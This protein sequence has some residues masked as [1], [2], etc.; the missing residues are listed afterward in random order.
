MNG[1]LVPTVLIAEDDP[2]DLFLI[3]SAVQK[4]CGEIRFEFV[5]DGAEVISYLMGEAEFADRSAYPY[6]VL[7]LTHLHL[8]KLDGLEVLGWIRLHS[9]HAGVRVVIWSDSDFPGELARA[10][11]AGAER[12]L[13]RPAGVQALTDC[14]GGILVLLKENFTSS[15]SS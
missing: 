2:A 12:V 6:P 9:E 5:R 1:P 8:R 11:N 3:R 15:S 14:L 4:I 10:K 7:I 13:R